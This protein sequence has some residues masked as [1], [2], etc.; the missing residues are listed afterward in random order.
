MRVFLIVAMVVLLIVCGCASISGAHR[1]EPP[2]TVTG[3]E[4]GD[5]VIGIALALVLTG[6][7]VALAYG[8]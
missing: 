5:W 7:T 3:N 1:E 6:A 8:G 2:R 4:T